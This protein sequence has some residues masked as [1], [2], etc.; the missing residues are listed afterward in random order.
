MVT[1]LKISGKWHYSKALILDE[2]RMQEL[3]KLILEFYERAEYS[4]TSFKGSEIQ[5][6]SIEE[7]LS[8]D[9]YEK[10]RIKELTIFGYNGYKHCIFFNIKISDS[11]FLNYYRTVNCT[12]TLDSVDKETLLL[13]KIEKFFSKATARYWLLGKFSLYGIIAIPSMLTSFCKY[14]VG[15]KVSLEVPLQM[16]LIII[17]GCI[18]FLF[19]IRWFDKHFL[20]NLFPPVSFLWGEELVRNE[21][22]VKL[23]SNVFWGII[24]AI[25]IGLVGTFIANSIWN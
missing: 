19:C 10:Q 8:Y 14:L 25:L 11:E 7:L 16:L 24:M 21:K 20:L 13:S 2:D 22:W 12:Y 23:R 17:I 4:A 3:N 9:N 18:G 1:Y 6:T 15:E 5:F